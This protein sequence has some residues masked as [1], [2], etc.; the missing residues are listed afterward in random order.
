MSDSAALSGFTIERLRAFCKIAESGSIALAAKGDPTRQSQFSRQVKELEEFF[1][2]K[3]LER[4]GKSV[5]LTDAGRKLALVT[6]SFFREIENLREAESFDN[7]IRIGAGES[8]LRWILMPQFT[9]L[10][11]LAPG[12]RFEFSTRSTVQSVEDVKAGKV[13]FAIVRKD[14]ADD[15]LTTLRCASMQYAFVVPRNL[16]PGRTAA[17]LQLLPRIPFALL[18]GDGVLA[19][20]IVTWAANERVNLDIQVKAENFSLLLSSIENADLAAVLPLPAVAGLSKERFATIQIDGIESLTRELV[21]VYSPHAAELR[22][23]I[24]RLAP[25][26]SSLLVGGQ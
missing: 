7:V 13:D 1:G 4:A 22:E 6:Q 24:R 19:K 5:R 2:T 26:L 16:L 21:L 18:T 11:S 14:A 12:V 17:G 20:R 10:K 23:A 25:R 9:E 8:I 15:T 3:L